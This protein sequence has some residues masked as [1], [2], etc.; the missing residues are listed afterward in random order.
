MRKF[1]GK[2]LALL[3]AL[4]MP[5][6]S[7][8]I[9][10]AESYTSE[11]FDYQAEEFDAA[12]AKLAAI[13]AAVEENAAEG[14][15]VQVYSARVQ[16]D[17]VPIAT[18]EEFNYEIGFMLN[19]APRYIDA[20]GEPQPAYTQYE[21]VEIT[22]TVP[23]GIVVLD[24][25]V[26]YRNP[27][28]YTISLG[29]LS[30][31]AGGLSRSETVRARIDKNGDVEDG[32]VFAP[33]GNVTITAKVSVEG[34][35]SGEQVTTETR[36]FTYTL[37][38]ARN[39]SAVTSAAS[40]DWMV[41]KD[42]PEISVGTDEVTITW[43]ITAGKVVNK[44]ITSNTSDYNAYGAL[45]FESFTLTDTLPTITGKDGNTYLPKSS[46]LSATGME[47]PVNGGEDETKLST[48]YYATTALTAGGVDTTIP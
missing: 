22:F 29:D 37:P 5:L 46:S 39:Q 44:A 8:P 12:A 48:N 1:A 25:G 36:T 11:P 35:T 23:V 15:Y 30:I 42:Q 43:V 20:T 2:C 26:E 7:M 34:V 18:G 24:A 10:L 27:A 21:D 9:S 28:T 16:G 40:G 6:T 47:Q 33:L 31:P 4:L 41:T 17:P 13:D 14:A 45:R 32:T 3:L 19:A 38:D